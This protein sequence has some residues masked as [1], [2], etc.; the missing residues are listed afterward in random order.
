M[1]GFGNV[2]G[3]STANRF[4]GVM[5]MYKGDGFAVGAAYNQQ[6]NEVGQESL[7]SILFGASVDLGPGKVSAL[8]GRSRMTIRRACRRS[9]PD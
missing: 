4:G 1:Y 3:N 2:A 9:L 7:R 8:Y 5:A 6:N